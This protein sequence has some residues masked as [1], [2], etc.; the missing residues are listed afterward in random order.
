M[1]KETAQRIS[2]M[3]F[4]IIRRNQIKDIIPHNLTGEY[5]KTDEDYILIGL[6]TGEKKQKIYRQDHKNTDVIPAAAVE[7]VVFKRIK[8]HSMAGDVH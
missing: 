5:G 3:P 6:D 1:H 4:Q 7:K 2:Q 8:Y